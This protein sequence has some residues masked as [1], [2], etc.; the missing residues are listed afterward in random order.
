MH[1]SGSHL[2][3]RS[4]I[5]VLKH[6]EISRI[7]LLK[8]LT[9]FWVSGPI[10]ESGVEPLTCDTQVLWESS[11]NMKTWVKIQVMVFLSH[12]CPFPSQ[13]LESRVSARVIEMYDLSVYK[14]VKC[15]FRTC[16]WVMWLKFPC[17]DI[18]RLLVCI[19]QCSKPK[20][21]IFS[22]APFAF[23]AC[24]LCSNI[25][26]CCSFI[27]FNQRMIHDFLS[28]PLSHKDGMVR[29]KKQLLS[30][31]MWVQ[32]V[33]CGCRL[34]C[35]ALLITSKSSQCWLGNGFCKFSVRRVPCWWRMLCLH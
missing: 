6:R 4:K 8:L 2:E 3:P 33:H 31:L 20:A 11:Q 12:L 29:G 17:L 24:Y 15:V 10:R 7:D 32:D 16:S 9:H 25:C 14:S 18:F 19:L 27:I 35:K 22:G 5:Q 21:K 34:I 28:K 1:F 13:L 30:N 26:C 23:F